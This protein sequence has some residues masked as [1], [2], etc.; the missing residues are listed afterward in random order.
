MRR[1]TCPYLGLKDDPPTSMSFPSPGNHCHNAKPI[2]PVKTSYQEKYCLAAEH[3]LCPIYKAAQPKPLPAALALPT[4]PKVDGRRF[5]AAVG[6]PILLAVIA[7]LGLIW[8]TYGAP[9][10][11]QSIIPDTSGGFLPQNS[12]HESSG[13]ERGRQTENSSQQSL[14]GGPLITNCPIPENWV[15]YTV[16]PTDSL[17]RL[18]V[19]Y[20]VSVE[21]LQKN[22]CMGDETVILPGRVI[23]VPFIPTN[24]APAVVNIPPSATP[25]PQ[26]NESGNDPVVV[27]PAT[28]TPVPPTAVSPT[29]TVIVPTITTVVPTTSVPPTSTAPAATNTPQA[30]NT[31]P[32]PTNTP[33]F[34]PPWWPFRTPTPVPTNTPPPDPI[35]PPPDPTNAGGGIQ[36]TDTADPQPDPTEPESTPE[37]PDLIDSIIDLILP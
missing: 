26:D 16:N 6:I 9:F 7:S 4:R 21:N 32:A 13:I 5:I 37:D 11:S 14:D 3:T 33:R 22:N 25:V 12:N 1:I 30:T 2:A 10:F 31:A 18:S 17:Y 19:I 36:E 34:P 23:Y 35:D 24:T 28:D 20:G 27:P 15:P 29:N 8:N